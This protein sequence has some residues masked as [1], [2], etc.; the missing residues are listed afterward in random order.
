MQDRS[1]EVY[2]PAKQMDPFSHVD[3]TPACDRHISLDMQTWT[4][5]DALCGR[6]KHIDNIC[7][8]HIYP[9]RPNHAKPTTL[10]LTALATR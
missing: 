5:P 7:D 4:V 3:I 10:L 2:V 8:A 6:Q 1:K 9:P